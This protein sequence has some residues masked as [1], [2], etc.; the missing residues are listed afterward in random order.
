MDDLG[1]AAR[2]VI[3]IRAY[4]IQFRGY[5]VAIVSEG[6]ASLLGSAPEDALRRILQQAVDA[7]ESDESGCIF[8]SRAVGGVTVWVELFG[9]TFEQGR[10]EGGH[11]SVFLPRE[12]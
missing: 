10:H 4:G 11:W 8:R 9:C 6:V 2:Q 5:P 1:K 7:G 12:R 3:D